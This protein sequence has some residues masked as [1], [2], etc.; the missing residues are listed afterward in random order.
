[1]NFQKLGPLTGL[2][3]PNL[4]AE[5]DDLTVILLH[6]Y[7]APGT[8]LVGLAAELDPPEGTRFVFLQAPLVLDAHAPPDYAPRAWWPLDMMELQMLRMTRQ[9]DKLTA[10]QPV[11]LGAARVGLS[12]A[13]QALERDHGLRRERLVLG[14]FSQG[15]MLATDFALRDAGALAGLVVLSGSML[16]ES[17]WREALPARTGLSVFQSHSPADQVLPFELAT[18]LAEAFTAAGL[19]SEFVSFAGGHGIGP[20]V[21]AGLSR[22][23]HSLSL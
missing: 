7:G 5:R 11:G 3:A 15:A 17:E 8:D 23:L 19:R 13:I 21:L 6:G 14:G 9:Y 20:S 1:M 12:Q 2:I 10:R 16:A 18:R 22:F 4:P